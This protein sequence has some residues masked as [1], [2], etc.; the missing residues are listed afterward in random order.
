MPAR[1]PALDPDCRH[2]LEL[3]AG[4]PE[5][6]TEHMLAAHG[7]SVSLIVDLIHAGL[8]TAH[9]QRMKVGT[10]EIEVAVVQITE[11]GRR[12]LAGS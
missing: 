11:E 7:I 9:P 4:S 10:K 6:T 1:T 5:P 12:A 2:A 8:A 3:L